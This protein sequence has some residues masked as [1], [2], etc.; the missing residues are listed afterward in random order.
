[1]L[2][3]CIYSRATITAPILLDCLLHIMLYSTKR[4][5]N[6]YAAIPFAFLHLFN[7]TSNALGGCCRYP[8]GLLLTL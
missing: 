6:P 1:M 4:S 2:P 7:P 3:M 5:S 8:C